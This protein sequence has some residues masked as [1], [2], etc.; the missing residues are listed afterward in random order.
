MR[1]LAAILLLI[2]ALTPVLW[3]REP[4]REGRPGPPDLRFYAL[5]TSAFET[6]SLGP[7]R[8]V[9]AWTIEDRSGRFGSYSG[10]VALGGGRLLTVS[11]TGLS[12]EFSAPGASD[13]RRSVGGSVVYPSADKYRQDA[14]AATLDPDTG[15]IWVAF[16]F[17][18]IVARF[19]NR[20]GKLVKSKAAAHPPAM[21]AWGN[22]SGPE[23]LARLPDGR[24]LAIRE[25]FT[26]MFERR[27]HQAVL[28][29]ADP[30]EHP[31]AA[32]RFSFVGPEGYSP[33]DATSLPDG[34]VLVLLRRVDWPMPPRFGGAIA[35]GDP[36]AIRRNREWPVRVL[37]TWRGGLPVDNFE[38]LAIEPTDEATGEEPLTLWVISDDNR[39]SL[40]RSVLWKLRFDLADLP[41]SKQKGARDHRTPSH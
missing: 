27:L 15:Q 10:L 28:F 13:R 6:R 1:R 21:S 25:G 24:F 34:R 2:A 39:A 38:G 22:N 18:N 5:D 3:L 37:A 26:A 19:E 31:D 8:L 20:H 36:R 23:S 32:T 11:D 29:A 9:N 41:K 35:I 16:E 7:F 40:Q 30:V 12:L 33:T 14:E 17:S 4:V